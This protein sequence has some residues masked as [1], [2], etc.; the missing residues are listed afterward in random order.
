MIMITI[1][2]YGEKKHESMQCVLKRVYVITE[3]RK[4]NTERKKL[5]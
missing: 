3:H 4:K 5:Y 2:L 1:I